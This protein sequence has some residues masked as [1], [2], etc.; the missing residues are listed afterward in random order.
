MSHRSSTDWSPDKGELEIAREFRQDSANRERIAKTAME[1][2]NTGHDRRFSAMLTGS[3]TKVTSDE[4]GFRNRE[5]RH[6]A[7]RVAEFSNSEDFMNAHVLYT[8]SHQMKAA[9]EGLRSAIGEVDTDTADIGGAE[10]V[11]APIWDV[12]TEMEERAARDVVENYHNLY[13]S[14]NIGTTSVTKLPFANDEVFKEIYHSDGEPSD[15]NVRNPEMFVSR[16]WIEEEH[17]SD[18]KYLV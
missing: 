12:V 6:G 10:H 13:D 8:A 16:Y 11:K 17:K 18:N 7:E 2:F 3:T 14:G 5:E 4:R 1:R 9:Y 15:H